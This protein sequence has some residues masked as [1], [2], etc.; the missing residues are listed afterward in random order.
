MTVREPPLA[1][2]QLVTSRRNRSAMG[3][4]MSPNVSAWSTPDQV[5]AFCGA[6]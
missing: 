6:R 1:G 3:G 4:Q 2:C 5:G